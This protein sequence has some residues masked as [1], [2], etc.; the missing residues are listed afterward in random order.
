MFRFRKSSL[1]V[2]LVLL[3]SLT[4]VACGTEDVDDPAPP[5]EETEPG[6]PDDDSLEDSLEDED[7]EEDPS[8]EEDN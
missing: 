5:V 7:V 8:D 4:L 2:A 1:M 6:A 3:L